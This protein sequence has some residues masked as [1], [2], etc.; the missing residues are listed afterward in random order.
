MLISSMFTPYDLFSATETK[1]IYVTIDDGPKNDM[2]V[3]L[4]ELGE[5]KVTFFMIGELLDTNYGFNIACKTLELG[6]EIGNH[7]YSH[8]EFSKISVDKAKKEIERTGKIINN[9]YKSV[10]KKNPLLFRFPY[11]D[12]G[13]YFGKRG[14]V[15]NRD[16]K[17][18]IAEFLSEL[19]YTTYYWT[20]DTED[21]KYYRGMS[22]D[23]I[24]RNLRKTKNND[25]V[26]MH[27]LPITI[28]RIIPYYVSMDYDMRVLEKPNRQLFINH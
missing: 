5:K 1:K 22:F 14:F 13:Y 27:D 8:P 10:G 11:G 24:M 25:I 16:K 12:S 7:S 26:L 19:G 17:K 3:I 18:E 4:E 28:K 2:D 9:V 23:K 21:W 20:L 15:G 6:H